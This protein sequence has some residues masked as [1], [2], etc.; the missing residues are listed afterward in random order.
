VAKN[1]EW[2]GNLARDLVTRGEWKEFCV[3]TGTKDE[4][5]RQQDPDDSPV[6][7]I[8]W[9]EAKAYADWVG[10]RLPTEE[11]L[12]DAETLI[13]GWV[14][15]ETDWGQWP[16][17]R[18]VAGAVGNTAPIRDLWGVVYQWCADGASVS[19]TEEE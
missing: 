12:K 13:K 17:D 8:T 10:H 14:D 1:I 11:E 7:G 15:A 2:Y 3:A 4:S 6:V 9:F 5:L 19:A 16:L 18:P